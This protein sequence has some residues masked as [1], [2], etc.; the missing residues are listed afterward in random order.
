MIFKNMIS[1]RFS[2]ICWIDISLGNAKKKTS[3]VKSESSS[4][5][6]T[7]KKLEGDWRTLIQALTPFLS[8]IYDTPFQ[9]QGQL[10]ED[11]SR[12]T[13][14]H[15]NIVGYLILRMQSMYTN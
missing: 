8:L 2:I 9:L 14:L 1:S 5:S 4:K 10:I 3:S 6:W 12:N 13:G 11:F 15:M 7:R